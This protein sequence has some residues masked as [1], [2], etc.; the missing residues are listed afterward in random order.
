MVLPPAGWSVRTIDPLVST[1]YDRVMKAVGYIVSAKLRSLVVPG[2][3]LTAVVGIVLA[4]V[5]TLAA[6][7]HR[8][9]TLPA[10]VDAA[11]GGG[12][13]FLVTQQQ[14]G[15]RP[16]TSQV[17]ALPGVDFADSYTFVFGGVA[18]SGA[19]GGVS[20]VV[21]SFVFAGSERAF[22]VHVVSGRA[23][24]Q[25]VDDEF[26][27][28]PTFIRATGAQV[29]D[30]FDLY[31]ISQDSA[32]AVGFD[33]R[34]AVRTLTA[35]L[36][37]IVAG[38]TTVDDPSAY[39]LFPHRLLDRPGVGIA[40]TMVPVRVDDGVDEATLRAELA[41]L[42]DSSQLSVQ[43]GELITTDL[44]RAITT[45][46]RGTWLLTL[47]AGFAALVTLT[48][49]V[50][51]QTRLPSTERQTLTAVGF[52][53]A[54]LFTESMARASVPIVA[55]GL[56]A[57]ALA[58]MFSGVFPTGTIGRFEP[59]PGV[60]VQ[61]RVLLPAAF[62]L[63]ALLLLLTGCVLALPRAANGVVVPSPVV[64][65][66]ASRSPVLPAAIGIRLGFTR[67]RGERGSLRTALAG[68]LFT[69]GG[70]V[71]AITFGSSL[72]RLIEEPYRYGWNMDASIGDNGGDQIDDELVAALNSDPN[73][74]SLIYYAQDYAKADD[75][76][77]PVMVMQRARGHVAPELLSG[78]L[79]VSEDEI[80]MGR[81]TARRVG[82]GVDDAVTLSGSAGSHTY[83]VVGLVVLTG[84]GSND[85]IGQGALTTLDGLRQISDAAV[86]GATVDFHS[87]DQAIATYF[88]DLDQSGGP[89]PFV[90]P[91][92][93]SLTRVRSVPYVLAA[94][95][96]VLVVL[97][98]T[99]TL[100]SSMRAR[101][102]DLAILRALGGPP[103]LLRR[104]IHWQATLVTLVPA[105]FGIPIGLIVGRL[106]FMALADDI[107]A[108]DD[109]VFPSGALAAVI[110]GVL[111]LAN[112]I[113]IWPAR[114]ARRLSAAAALRTE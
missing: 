107:G 5:I 93:V 9:E 31:T 89:E 86:T 32:A 38:P 10:R 59:S 91:D 113:A 6:G 7:A 68:V 79:P 111:V 56:V 109:A 78:R 83:R 54:Q 76:D 33:P 60:L 55:G 92:I 84:L 36:V 27:A 24:N 25:D 75:A 46:A 73:V 62:I 34:A 104:S 49:V 81:V 2:V 100:L 22:A 28:S 96:G 69:V 80:A 90:P 103:S 57:T 63:V 82:V 58:I 26:V 85:G 48:Q 30:R 39:V 1:P 43:S 40:L 106:V 53:N 4:I 37:G 19:A 14:T 18:P 70:L 20:D 66:L 35:T 105:L 77:V 101:R 51:R 112:V 102:R 52:S 87:R 72:D 95:L 23:M 15:Q 17:A 12:F 67:A 114:L 98:I 47:V 45:Q 64:N 41:R 99:Q 29:G 65:T 42:P 110:V 8:T 13:D 74:S 21:D 71:G 50:A 3:V 94:L 108:V 44:R 61:W 97:T 11:A 88:P 16:L